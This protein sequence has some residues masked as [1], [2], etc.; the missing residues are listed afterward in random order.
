MKSKKN[1]QHLLP[2]MITSHAFI[3]TVLLW[4]TISSIHAFT[5]V[6]TTTCRQ[7]FNQHDHLQQQQQHRGRKHAGAALSPAMATDPNNNNG[8]E[9][10]DKD[11]DNNNESM[12]EKI[13]SF[14][15]TPFFDPNAPSNDNNWFANLV[16]DDYE[17]AE[18]L[19]AGVVV[20][21]G[22]IVSQDLL[23]IVKYGGLSSGG[24]GGGGNLF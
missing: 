18:A 12:D 21:F 24:G 14:L 7:P 1:T 22:V 3:K 20:I 6:T 23:R 19:Y 13:D 11:N 16:K 5:G 10:N 8:N 9:T 17:S 4:H 2:T 15:D